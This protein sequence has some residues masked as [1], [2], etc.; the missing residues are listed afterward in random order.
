MEENEEGR[1]RERA[2]VFE[3]KFPAS[4][5]S[6]RLA[7]AVASFAQDRPT[8]HM[9]GATADSVNIT[10]GISP[11]TSTWLGDTS[12]LRLEYKILPLLVLHTIRYLELFMLVGHATLDSG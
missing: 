10:D 3:V 4:S 7:N 1:C 9:K 2:L 12:M 11:N 6:W 8:Q 5:G